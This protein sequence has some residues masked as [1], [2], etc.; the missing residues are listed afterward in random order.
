[1]VKTP[2]NIYRKETKRNLAFITVV[3]DEYIDRL[4]ED[5]HF[6]Q[7]WDICIL[8][9]KPHRF[10][11]AMYVEEYTNTVFS[12]VDKVTFGLRMSLKFKRSGFI[13][14]ADVIRNIE[15]DFLNNHQTYSKFTVCTYWDNDKSDNKYI[16]FIK[17]LRFYTEEYGINIDKIKPLQEQI[18]NI[19]YSDKL[20]DILYEVERI[21]PILEF[22]SLHNNDYPNLGHGEGMALAIAL[23]KH[24]MQTDIFKSNP[25]YRWL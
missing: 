3:S 10:P 22:I 14:D 2:P 20:L 7:N 17:N 11:N 16:E 5:L 19:P 1:M 4:V 6:L 13:L 8:T 25:F 9:D 21:K 12:Y 23:E 15:P 18:L 24:G